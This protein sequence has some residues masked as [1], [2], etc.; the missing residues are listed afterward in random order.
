MPGTEH[1]TPAAIQRVLR[2]ARTVAVLGAHPQTER[3]AHYVP[4]YLAAQGMRI[5]PVNA[6]KV[7]QR[8]LGEAVIES[9]VQ[10]AEQ[11]DVVDVFRRADALP[12][13]LAEIL[14]MQPRPR[15][16]WLQPG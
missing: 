5:I 6:A 14:E 10:V 4:A 9:L 7:G 16:V 13:H 11:V 1:T 12:G 15:T 2:E 3:P 8:I